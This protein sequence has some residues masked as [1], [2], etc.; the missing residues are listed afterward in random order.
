MIADAKRRNLKGEIM[1]DLGRRTPVDWTHVERYPLDAL[2]EEQQP[3]GVPAVIGINWYSNFDSPVKVG[4]RWFI[5]LDKNNLGSMRGGHAICVKSGWQDDQWGW[6]DFYA[7]Q[8]GSCTGFSGARMMS[9][10]NRKRYEAYWL[11]DRN[12]EN[13]QFNDT[14]P[15]DVHGS[16]VNAT[17]Y[18]LKNIGLVPV[19][20]GQGLTEWDAVNLRKTFNP[21]PSDGISAY[22]WTNNAAD[23]LRVLNT[24]AQASLGAVPLLNSWGRS[25]P[26]KVWLPVETLQRLLDED[27]ECALITDY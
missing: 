4:Q 3:S 14:N 6:W 21:V 20:R 1:G 27:G 8:K 15:G 11:W 7:Q 19:K 25:Y 5:G 13:D 17:M 22:R 2:P 24:P 16:T 26:R 12:K 10:L 18:V 23:L 9:L